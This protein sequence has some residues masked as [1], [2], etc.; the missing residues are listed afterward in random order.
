VTEELETLYADDHSQTADM[1][2]HEISVEAT[3]PQ[4]IHHPDE[5]YT[6][7]L[8]YAGGGFGA[9]QRCRVCRRVF[10]KVAMRDGN[11]G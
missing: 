10:G 2:P 4:C 11:D 6:I 8:G 3:A 9:Y 1:H 5:G 7:G